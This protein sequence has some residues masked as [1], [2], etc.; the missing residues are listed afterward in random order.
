[1]VRK[2]VISKMGLKIKF[3]Y[4]VFINKKIMSC[5]YNEIELFLPPNKRMIEIVK[6]KFTNTTIVFYTT[7]K[8]FLFDYHVIVSSKGDVLFFKTT[9]LCSNWRRLRVATRQKISDDADDER[10]SDSE[11]TEDELDSLKFVHSYIKR[12]FESSTEL[13]IENSRD[14]I[15]EHYKLNYNIVN[16]I[17]KSIDKK[18]KNLE[19]SKSD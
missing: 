13:T 7:F 19:A 14:I 9:T 17:I 16:S 11:D 2:Q 18:L 15:Y 5:S 10:S 6:E 1:M 12:R 8:V 4:L 3:F